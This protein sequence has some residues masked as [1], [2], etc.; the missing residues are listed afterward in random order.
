MTD[1]A[2]G[3]AAA[4]LSMSGVVKRYEAHKAVNDLSLAIPA[5]S[6]AAL[7]G[8]DGAGKTTVIRMFCGLAAPDQGELTVAGLAWQDG[9]SRLKR[10]IGYLS[11]RFSLYGDLTVDENIEFF[12]E[13]HELAGF[14]ERRDELLAFTRLAAFRK[15]LADRLSGGMKQKLALACTLIHRPEILFLDEPTTGVDPVSRR[16]FWTILSQLRREG[17]TMLIATPYMDEAERCDPVILMYEGRSVMNG[18]PEELKRDLQGCLYEV[19][20]GDNRVATERLRGL[21]WVEEVEL[22]GDR[23][24]V[25]TRAAD[26]IERIRAAVPGAG[27]RVDVRGIPPGIEDVFVHSL[28][29]AGQ[30]ALD[31][32]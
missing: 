11:Q 18:S 5:G 25:F 24:H 8:P 32:A 20:A 23:V 17:L 26:A 28:R 22:F 7:V 21:D 3:S 9:R 13:L 27:G 29:R 15:R 12:A 30:G 31:D 6:M 10:K 14:A 19:L 2:S 16:E 4:L 1:P